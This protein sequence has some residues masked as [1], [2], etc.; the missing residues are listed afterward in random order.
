MSTGCAVTFTSDAID[1]QLQRR[2][3]LDNRCCQSGENFLYS[4][5][6]A[7]SAPPGAT[8]GSGGLAGDDASGPMRATLVNSGRDP[9]GFGFNCPLSAGAAGF[10]APYTKPA[11]GRGGLPQA[12]RQPVPPRC[13][14][15]GVRQVA[16][17]ARTDRPFSS[18][19]ASCRRT[20]SQSRPLTGVRAWRWRCAP[21]LS[22]IFHGKDRRL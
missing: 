18:R 3:R 11:S 9:P 21:V 19:L 8:A 12:G 4:F 16:V 22:V 14:T 10:A 7:R 5:K 6:G 17:A 15:D 2:S 1:Q 13:L 20:R